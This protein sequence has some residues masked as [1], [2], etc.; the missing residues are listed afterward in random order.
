[1]V[2]PLGVALALI[3]G[4]G[5]LLQGGAALAGATVLPSMSAIVGVLGGLVPAALELAL[6]LAFLV[7]LVVALGRWHE[8]GTWTALRACGVGGRLLLRPAL[9]CALGVA[10][11][12]ATLGHG[13]VP[14][15][16]RAASARLVRACAEVTLPPGG[17]LPLAGAMLHRPPSGGLAA[18]LGDG[19]LS[20]EDGRL[21]PRDGGVLLQLGRG[22]ALLGGA[23]APTLRFE[24]AA[25]PL[26]LRASSRRVELAE[27][28]D[29]ELR[30]LVRRRAASGQDAA[31]PRLILLKRSSLAVALL[32]LPAV[33]LPMALRWGG[34]VLPVV[35]VALFTWSLVRVGDGLAALIGAWPAAA[36]PLLGLAGVAAAL[37]AGWRDR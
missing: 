1:M 21:E 28:T 5:L 35:G 8:D 15:G 19:F 32:L 7:G 9:L 27:R 17:F 33:V 3:T 26:A 16:R 37:W 20:A 25:V 36:L 14:A 2:G 34:R 10:L 23:G 11:L 4:G 29:A 24:A 30:A 13:V 31:Y 6:P 12:L 22:E 18:S